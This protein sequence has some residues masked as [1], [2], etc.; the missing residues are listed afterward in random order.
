MSP[1]MCSQVKGEILSNGT[2]RPTASLGNGLNP[3]YAY[4]NA[5][6]DTTTGAGHSTNAGAVSRGTTYYGFSGIVNGLTIK[7]RRSYSVTLDPYGLGYYGVVSASYTTDNGSTW[8]YFDEHNAFTGSSSATTS[9]V[10]QVVSGQIDLANFKVMIQSDGMGYVD[11]NDL[12]KF[13][14]SAYTLY[15]L[16][17]Q[18]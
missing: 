16:Y 3:G 8:N 15:D 18:Y 7:I 10:T 17:I 2:Q 13:A 6:D 14:G 5:L 4:D 1:V 11:P 9:P 12:A